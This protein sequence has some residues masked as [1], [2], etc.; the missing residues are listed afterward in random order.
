MSA[1]ISEAAGSLSETER[2]ALERHTEGCAQCQ[3]T[4]VK[5]RALWSA[6]D[7]LPAIEPSEDFDRRLYVRIA[8]EER[9]PWWRATVRAFPSFRM[10]SAVP[11]AAACLALCGAL[12]LHAPDPVAP[13]EPAKPV[14]VDNRIDI[15]VDQVEQTL[16]DLEMLRQLTVSPPERDVAETTESQT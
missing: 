3:D 4:L 12:L 1:L 9:R 14:A 7:E 2:A 10:R 11:V 15:D 16:D 8:E 13:Q 5:Q 6:L